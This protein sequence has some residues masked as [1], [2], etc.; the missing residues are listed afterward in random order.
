MS[1]TA[2]IVV[3]VIAVPMVGIVAWA[4]LSASLVRIPP[5]RLGLLLIHGRATDTTLLPGPHLVFAL[6]RRLVQEYPS[7][8]LTYRCGAAVDAGA[9]E[10]ER[11]GTALQLAL[12]D[13]ATAGVCYAVRFRLVPEHLRLVHERFGPTGVFGVVR[14]VSSLAVAATLGHPDVGVTDLFGAAREDLQTRAEAVVRE[15]L[16]EVGVEVCS[17]ILGPV[18]LGRLGEVISA[19]VRTRHELELE[20]AE[21]ATRLA[22]AAN[23]R[24]LRSI[25]TLAG[26]PW[27]YR[28]A[29]LL[30]DLVHGS[31]AAQIA[32]HTGE[33]RGSAASGTTTGSEDPSP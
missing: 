18:D 31:T 4:I 2:W 22:R 3:L 32:L 10:L 8:E 21:A 1:T 15:R 17:F 26:E 24:E 19:T 14:D 27:R 12:G 7:V 9:E 5:G 30:R 28:E 23:D 16:D 29:D 20:E 25:L 6:R 13:R 11:A 33:A